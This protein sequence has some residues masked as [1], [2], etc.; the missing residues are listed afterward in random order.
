V[1]RY[2]LPWFVLTLVL[3]RGGLARADEIDDYVKTRMGEFHLPGLSLVV[4]K[5]G[6]VVKAAG[7]G[8]ADVARRTPVT[9]DTVFKIGSVSKQFIASAIMLL[10]QDGRLSVED[11]V[12]KYLMEVPASWQSIT[13]RQLLTHTAGLVRE[14]PGFNPMQA[15]SD[16]DIVKSTFPVPLLFAPGSK[17]AYSNAGYYV[18][19][20]IISRVSGQSWARFIEER[21]FKTAGMASTK[22]TNTTPVPPN[23]AVGYTGNDNQR[24]AGEWVALRPS[25]AF[26]STVVD[27]AKWEAVL[28]DGQVL[29]DASRRAMWA[30]V[31]LAD[32][33]IADYG[34]G[35][36]VETLLRRPTVWHG[37]AFPGF[38]SNYLRF[39]DDGITVIVL[40]NGD[41]VDTPG[42]TL[43]IAQRYLP[44]NS[45]R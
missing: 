29:N 42:I 8:F 40:A 13:L 23:R 3:V 43:G 27:L 9:V 19:A 7:Y 25:G 10:A 11:P 24:P 31:R 41:D 45:S 17:W 16:L 37:G 1:P 4:L 34:F 35:W 36:H 33:T 26:L 39:V 14:S 32:G 30:R 22:P 15:A 38:T 2:R 12:R 18:L 5:D 28:R 20:E 21:L 6:A 44:P